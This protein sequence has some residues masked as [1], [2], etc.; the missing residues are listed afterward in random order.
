MKLGMVSARVEIRADKVEELM[1][2]VEMLN[3]GGGGHDNDKC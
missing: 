1:K 3:A 2:I